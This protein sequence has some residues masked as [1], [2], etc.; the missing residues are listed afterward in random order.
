MS[1]NTTD[2]TDKKAKKVT[3]ITNPA[4]D[5]KVIEKIITARVGLLLKAPFFGNL[6]TRLIVKN[7]DDWLPTAATDGR[8]FYYNSEFVNQLSVRQTEFLVCHEILHCVYDHMG[9]RGDRDAQLFNIAADYCVN[10]DIVDQ[11]IGEKI[12]QVPILLD[13]KYKGMCAE[14]VYDLLYKNADKLNLKQLID[15]MLDEHLDD[16]EDG[17]D[18]EGGVGGEDGK[19]GKGGRPKYTAEER[20]Q[21]RDEIKEAVLSAAQACG[22]GNLPSG[23]RRMLSDLTE[24][25]MNWRELLRQQIESTIKSDYTWMKPSRR[26]WH[27]EACMPAQNVDNMI[28]ICVAVDTSGSMSTAMLRDILSEVHGI[29]EIHA[30]AFVVKVW[31]FDAQVYNLQTFTQENLDEI[32]TYEMMGGGGTSFNVNWDFMK[33]NEIEP[34]KLVFFTDGFSGDGWG[35]ELYCDTLWIIHSNPGCEA[36]YGLTVEYDA[37]A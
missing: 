4:T 15:S 31:C 37:A 24:P 8:Y 32:L 25:K 35:D 34:K 18:S 22:A 17:D 23:I 2:A 6:G 19:S 9:R 11:N 28:D 20:K 7:A 26:A 1:G 12:T 30:N 21:I 27:S 13:S 16:S 29:M 14:E 10:Q 5:A 33:E 3:T 36:P